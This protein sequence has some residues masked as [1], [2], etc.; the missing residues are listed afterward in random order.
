MSRVTRLSGAILAESQGEY[1]L[2]GNTKS[3]CDWAA[4]GFEP[5]GELDPLKR[6]YIRLSGR[7]SGD[8]RGGA[9]IL[10]L[11]G[12]PLAQALAQRFLIERNGSV[13]ERLWRLVL[14]GGDPDAEGIPD[15]D[16]DA[17]WLGEIPAPL[18][19]IIRDTVLRC[20]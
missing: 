20:L 16:V 11:E 10:D 15:A 13:S 12:E 4:A 1:F 9:L 8:A 7:G 2:I 3:P 19:Q 5:P 14:H 6:P 18:W 17:R